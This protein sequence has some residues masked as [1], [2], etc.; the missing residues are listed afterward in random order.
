MNLQGKRILLTG[1]ARGLGLAAVQALKAQGAVVV[2][3]DKRSGQEQVADKFILADLRDAQAVKRAVREAIDYLGGLDILINN[4]GVLSLQD[5]GDHPNQDVT[6]A[7]QVN[8]LA[9]W[10]VT[11]EALPALRE[12]RGRVINIASLFAVVNAPFIPAYAATKRALAAYSDILRM[13]H[14]DRIS[15]TTL[16]PGYINTPIHDTAEA[17]GLSVARIV[18]FCLGDK[19]V[20]SFEEQ[21]DKA[22]AGVVRACAGR[23][24]RERGLTFTGTLTLLLARH[25]PGLVDAIVKWRLGR[26]VKSGMQV[27]LTNH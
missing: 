4:A 7:I 6:E 25:A 27:V 16:Y 19:K 24:V 12:A 3:I 18:T 26:L 23:P 10:Q 17:Q 5:A 15:V 20:L 8:L 22:A 21:M 9:P 14:G 1:A 11:T 13:Q 2:G